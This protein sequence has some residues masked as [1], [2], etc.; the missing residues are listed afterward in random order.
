MDE[1]ID[2]CNEKLEGIRSSGKGF[3]K[4][5]YYEDIK[6]M[7]ERRNAPIV[8]RYNRYYYSDPNFSFRE[9]PMS[10]I[11]RENFEQMVE[12]LRRF[13][14]VSEDVNTTGLRDTIKQWLGNQDTDGEVVGFDN[15]SN[16]EGSSW[17]DRVFES[18]VKR[19]TLD[20]LYHPFGRDAKTHTVFPQYLKQYNGR[21]FLI[22]TKPGEPD[23]PYSFALERIDELTENQKVKYKKSDIDFNGYFDDVIGMT[24]PH[25]KE[26]ENVVLR[27][28]KGEYP[29][30][31]TKPL[32]WSQDEISEDDDSVT[33]KLNVVVNYE[34][35]QKILAY[36]DHVTV[37][38]PRS[39]RDSMKSM[40]DRMREN[41][42]D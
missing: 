3:S 22:A 38:E 26:A 23:M 17:Y 30:L 10:E 8:K 28:A 40:I 25:G 37:M 1:L 12:L 32:H 4:R 35:K 39:L 18:I 21:W 33:I 34:L 7:K 24:R 16:Y 36:A 11:D 31:E 41:Y 2:R 13:C 14:N 42:A 15:P 29:Y 27:V 9:Q 20:I 6:Y 19:Q 5:Q